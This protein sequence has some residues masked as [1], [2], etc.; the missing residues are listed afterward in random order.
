MKLIRDDD[1]TAELIKRIEKLRGT[2]M[3]FGILGSADGEV[4]LYASVHE[5]G[6]PSI[7]I[8]ERSFLRKTFDDKIDDMSNTIEDL[9]GQYIMDEIGYKA[10]TDAIGEYVVGLIR[11]TIV[12]LKNPPLKPATIAAK[13]SSQP[14]ID[15][16]QMLDSID[17]EVV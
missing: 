7:N 3:K 16:G 12:E 14:L 1:D 2:K 15:T 10:M 5:F 11:Q 4:L 6:A 17:Y 9:V 8:P 13:G